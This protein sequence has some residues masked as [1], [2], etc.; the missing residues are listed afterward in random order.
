MLREL[1]MG[2]TNAALHDSPSAVLDHVQVA[3]GSREKRVRVYRVNVINSLT[4][5]LAAAFPVVQRI[6]GARFFRAMA[7]TFIEAH[8][9][10]EPMLYRYGGALPEFLDTYDPAKDVPYVAAVARLEW[11]RVQAYFAADAEPLDAQRLAAVEPEAL[12]GVTF[13]VHPAVHVISAEFPV[14][15]IWQVNQPQV[16]DIP[17]IDLT[18][19]EAGVVFRRGHEVVQR[20]ISKSFAAWLTALAKGEALGTATELAAADNDFDLQDALRQTL[21]DGVFTDISA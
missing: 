14:F 9:P 21:A 6:V 18:R 15:K 17:R 10:R 7:K 12:E 4:D 11:A 1:Q 3:R 13:A 2:L 20:A 19:A 8:P 16:T 5:V